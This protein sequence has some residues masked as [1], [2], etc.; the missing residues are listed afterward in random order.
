MKLGAFIVSLWDEAIK[1]RAHGVKR[2]DIQ[3]GLHASL[4]DY[5]REHGLIA[6]EREMPYWQMPKCPVCRD[7]GWEPTTRQVRGEMM[8]AYRRCTCRP[9]LEAQPDRKAK[10]AD[11]VA[12]GWK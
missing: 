10:A 8:E 6:N 5:A 1:M 3:R 7:S 4:V 9:M 11:K 2:E 12:A